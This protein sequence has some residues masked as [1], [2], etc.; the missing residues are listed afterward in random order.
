MD[1]QIKKTKE[2]TGIAAAE[3]AAK[4]INQAV[5]HNNEVNIILATGASQF[6]MLAHLVKQDIRWS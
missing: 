4:I 3:L 5:Q 2:E 1:I 6:E